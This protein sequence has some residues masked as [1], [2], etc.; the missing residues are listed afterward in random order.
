[1]YKARA[2]SKQAKEWVKALGED[3]MGEAAESHQWVAVKAIKPTPHRR[4]Q[5]SSEI[6]IMK[7]LK[8]HPNI[9]HFISSH[10]HKEDNTVWIAMS[11]VEGKNL[12]RIVHDHIYKARRKSVST[13]AFNEDETRKLAEMLFG[14]LAVVHSMGCTHGDLHIGNIMVNQGVPMLID[15]GEGNFMA[16][17]MGKDVVKLAYA[18]VECCVKPVLDADCCVPIPYK[19]YGSSQIEAMRKVLEMV[20]DGKLE[21]PDGMRAFVK[22]ILGGLQNT[23]TANDPLIQQ[24][25]F[26]SNR[27]A[28]R[29][30]AK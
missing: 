11:W 16:E 8:Q 4:Q 23:T 19:Q 28:G 1:M 12:G 30:L 2:I 15:F 25:P 20:A 22:D 14:A 27:E 17:E 9:V 7:Q 18:L 5:I 24:H 26:L 29:A 3:Q 10:L 6:R 13:P 21:V